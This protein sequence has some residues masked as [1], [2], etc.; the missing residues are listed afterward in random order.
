MNNF[1]NN[2][3]RDLCLEL[4]SHKFS[5]LFFVKFIIADFVLSN[6]EMYFQNWQ[7][8]ILWFGEV[9]GD[10]LFC[11]LLIYFRWLHFLFV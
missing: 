4:L 6:Q 7:L 3:T 8:F 5:Q 1:N 10:L 2:F 9:H 11:V